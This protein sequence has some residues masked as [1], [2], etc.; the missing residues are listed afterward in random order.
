[1]LIE[2][3]RGWGQANNL[4]RLERPLSTNFN[5]FSPTLAGK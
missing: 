5:H 4:G 1:M 3:S 2:F